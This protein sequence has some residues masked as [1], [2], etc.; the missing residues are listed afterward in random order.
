MTPDVTAILVNYN[1]GHEL[2]VAL[3]SIQSD[4]AQVEWEAVVVDNASPLGRISFRLPEGP[5]PVCRARLRTGEAR[6][7]TRLDTVIVDTDTAR[8]ILW[9]RG[10]TALQ[11]GPLDVI[12]GEITAGPP[13][14]AA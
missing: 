14:K 11:D 12:E 9:Y 10:H 13:A 7:E 8:V 5:P 2:A 3:R 4:C 1:A 6:I